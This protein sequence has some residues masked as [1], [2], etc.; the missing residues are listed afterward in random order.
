MS[1]MFISEFR[2]ITESFRLS[3]LS[4]AL[5]SSVI[6]SLSDRFQVEA[7]SIRLFLGDTLL[8]VDC[9]F[10]SRARVNRPVL[11][12]LPSDVDQEGILD[13]C[14]EESEDYL[15]ETIERYIPDLR[16]IFGEQWSREDCFTSS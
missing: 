13:D 16:N 3:I 12:S 1:E 11:V 9:V 4:D 6:E 7:S 8:P 15:P 5:T 14:E 10:S 2:T